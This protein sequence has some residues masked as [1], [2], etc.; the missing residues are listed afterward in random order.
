MSKNIFL[1]T[2]L[3]AALLVLTACAAP[4]PEPQ[5][6]TTPMLDLDTLTAESEFGTLH[7]QQADSSYVGLIEE[8]RAIGIAFSDEV[9]ADEAGS[10][11]DEIVV[12]LYDRQDMA[13]M[14]GSTDAEGTARLASAELSDFEA[15]VELVMEEGVVTGMVTFP[16]EQPASFTAI[17]ATGAGGV[18]WAQGDVENPDVRCDWIVLPDGR[19]WGCICFPPTY[20]NPC[21]IIHGF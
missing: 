8:G 10:L 11:Q 1:K 3:A 18:Y 21:C 6:P 20:G 19:Q 16:G 2:I 15:T 7:A 14:T 9:T 5:E 4:V 13:I 17:A 12:Y